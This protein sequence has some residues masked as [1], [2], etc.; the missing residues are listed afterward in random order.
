[1]NNEQRAIWIGI[2]KHLQALGCGYYWKL[3]NGDTVSMC[4]DYTHDL[5]ACFRDFVPKL[6]ELKDVSGIEFLR[7][8]DVRFVQINYWAGKNP[9]DGYGI[10]VIEGKGDTY[11]EAFCAAVDK[12]IEKT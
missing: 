9:I 8:G 1:M 11:S 5:N 12:I 6:Y 4:P 10:S 3:K 7:E 2:E